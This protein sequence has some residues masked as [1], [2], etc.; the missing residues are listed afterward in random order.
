MAA[1]SERQAVFPKTASKRN[2]SWKK[3]RS[4]SSSG[5]SGQTSSLEGG[6]IKIDTK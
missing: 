1:I 5:S 6:M 2:K 4:K 3:M